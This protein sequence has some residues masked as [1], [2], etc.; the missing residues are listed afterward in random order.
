MRSHRERLPRK[1]DLGP[2]EQN[3]LENLPTGTTCTGHANH[4]NAAFSTTTLSAFAWH[5]ALRFV[6]MPTL[7]P[8]NKRSRLTPGALV[9]IDVPSCRRFAFAGGMKVL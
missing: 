1:G 6:S 9:A 4:F 8:G 3:A 5:G 2:N 7:S